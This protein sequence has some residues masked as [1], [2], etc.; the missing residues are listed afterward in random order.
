MLRIDGLLR[1]SGVTG[2]DIERAVEGWTKAVPHGCR[3]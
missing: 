3:T 1:P 2:F